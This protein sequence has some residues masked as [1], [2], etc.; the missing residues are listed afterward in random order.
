MPPGSAKS[1]ALVLLLGLGLAWLLWP[2]SKPGAYR[3]T[4]TPQSGLEITLSIRPMRSLQ[5]DWHREITISYNGEQISQDL[6]GDTGWWRGSNLYRHVSGAYLLHEGQAGCV[7]LTLEPLAF[8][9][10]LAAECSQSR[11]PSRPVE[12]HSPYY[13]NLIYLGHFYE[14][15]RDPE[16]VRLKFSDPGQTAEI[17]LPDPL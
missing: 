7:G 15:W 4:A 3:A 13:T 14:T 6:L 9:M 12:G 11:P 2:L 5:S 10:G 17:K 8:D 16:G 1:W